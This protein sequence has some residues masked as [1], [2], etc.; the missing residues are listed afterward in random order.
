MVLSAW[1]RFDVRLFILHSELLRWSER[2]IVLVA[3][4]SFLFS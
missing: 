4:C 2:I 3:D 1:R